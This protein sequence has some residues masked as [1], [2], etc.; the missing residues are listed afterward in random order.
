[1][2]SAIILAAGESKRMGLAPGGK[3]LLPLGDSTILE[4]TIDNVVASAVDET[5][6]VLGYSAAEIR[7]KIDCRPVKIVLNSE[8]RN[9]MSTSVIAGL[10]AVEAG[11]EAILLVLGDQPF[12]RS[13]VINRLISEYKSHDKG[14]VVP[15]YRGK[16]GHPVIISLSYEYLLLSIKGD[17]G[18][19]E[20]IYHH[21]DDVLEVEMDSVEITIDID[22]PEEYRAAKGKEAKRARY[23]NG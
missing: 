16:R 2:I 13:Q 21:P 20:I 7:S 10:K 3:Q 17:V 6:V 23:H 18:A 22:T 8:Y 4:K 11:T 1:M 9:G 12:I 15:S 14:I 19:R 5:I